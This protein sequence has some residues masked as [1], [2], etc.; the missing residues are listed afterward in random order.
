[1]LPTCHGSGE[2]ML[3]STT[4]TFTDDEVDLIS[5]LRV[6]WQS[7]WI[8]VVI[9]ALFGFGSVFVALTATPIFR[10]D[11]VIAK[12]GNTNMS[13][14]ATLANQLG[15]LGNLVGANFGGGGPERKAQ[16]FLESRRLA[17]EFI[18]RNGLI[19]ELSPGDGVPDSLWFTVKRFRETVLS[20]NENLTDG[21]TTVAMNWTDPEVAARWAND[22]VALANEMIRE[23]ARRDAE[24][25]IEYLNEQIAA[26]SIVGVEKVMYNLLESETK[27][28]MLANGREEFAFT[29]IDPAV[30]PEM[31]TRPRRKLIV[32]S[33][34]AL[35]VFFGVVAVFLFKLFQQ[36]RGRETSSVH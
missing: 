32:M 10:A 30:T 33:G 8:I 13:T 27:T 34:G 28:L 4:P 25:N 23:R 19:D 12:A 18:L 1:M 36:V 5:F 16:E 15:G 22:Y 3:V 35:G 31:R 21:V 24:R 2:K 26:T 29:V 9:T 17:E 11:T 14:A 7:K 6:L 20:I